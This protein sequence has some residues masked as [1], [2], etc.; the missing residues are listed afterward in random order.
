M[1]FEELYN[2]SY[3]DAKKNFTVFHNGSWVGGKLIK[4]DATRPMYK[5]TTANKKEM[6]VTDNHIFPTLYG[7]KKVSEITNDDYIMFNTRKLDTF[8][9]KDKGLTYEEGILIGMYLGDGSIYIKENSTPTISLSLNE[10][11]YKD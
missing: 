10:T 9:E 2:S 7:D 6:V 11:K 3:K 5:V 4:L 1:T 8:P